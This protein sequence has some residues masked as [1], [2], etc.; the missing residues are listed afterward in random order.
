VNTD[1][2]FFRAF[3]GRVRQQLAD[4]TPKGGTT[5]ST[6]TDTTPVP[7]TFKPAPDAVCTVPWCVEDGVHVEHVGR[8]VAL[9][10]VEAQLWQDT[11]TAPVT[12]SVGDPKGEYRTI[13]S[14]DQLRAEAARVR[15]SGA[16]L[17]ALADEFDAIREGGTGVGTATA[18]VMIGRGRPGDFDVE[19]W[20]VTGVS[21]T[22]EAVYNPGRISL[23]DAESKVR[24]VLADSSVQ[25][26][27]FLNE[28]TAGLLDRVAD[29]IREYGATP[30]QVEAVR[31]VVRGV[32]ESGDVAGA[33]VRLLDAAGQAAAPY[34]P[35]T[36]YEERERVVCAGG[37]G[38]I[39][40]AVLFDPRTDEFY[41]G[42]PMTLSVYSE[43]GSD[44]DLDAAGATRLIGDLEQ[45]LPRLRAMRDVLAGQKADAHPEQRETAGAA[46][47]VDAAV[48]LA[49][50]AVSASLAGLHT[51]PRTVAE[52]LHTA[53]DNAQGWHLAEVGGHSEVEAY[54]SSRF[55][56]AVEAM[57]HAMGATD[58]PQRMAGALR[59]ALDMVI[60]EAR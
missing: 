10:V 36:T 51:N 41:D 54:A 6:T 5:M 11:D 23:K 28:D 34:T 8:L 37:R 21:Y 4:T 17:D 43:P 24:D 38:A 18:V 33:G 48:D 57:T 53:I 39:I 3:A 47:L 55:A 50:Q 44:A 56:T 58:H 46:G 19:V 26:A 2:E 20:P 14:G 35:P 9:P 40:N 7:A 13:T 52:R 42:A 12:V 60:G 31:Q 59:S 16:R 29:S 25:V 30:E 1:T 49:V 32:A 15:A 27:R 45:L 22:H